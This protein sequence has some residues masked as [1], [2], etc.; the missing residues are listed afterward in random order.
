MQENLLFEYA[1]IRIVPQVEREEFLNTGVILYCAG[2]KFLKAIIVLDTNRIQ[3]FCPKLDIAELA[4]FTNAFVAICQGGNKGG[5][6]GNLILPERFRWLT[7]RRSTVLQTSMV[8]PG[9]CADPDKMLRKLF[10]ELVSCETL[11]VVKNDR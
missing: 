5:A 1:V 3:V 10:S 11:L 4:E 9:F 8:H 6:I 7:A 2:Q